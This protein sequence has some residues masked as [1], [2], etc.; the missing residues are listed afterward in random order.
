MVDKG[1]E[2]A[3][4]APENVPAFSTAQPAYAR[5]LQRLQGTWWKRIV[6]V[7]APYRRHIRRLRLGRLLDIGCGTGRNLVHVGGAGIGIDHNASLV[8]IARAGGLEAYTPDEFRLSAHAQPAE[9]DSLLYS[10]ILEHM[11]FGEAQQLL[12]D[13]LPFLRLG[14]RVVMITP[15]E[16]GY[17]SDPTHVEF[18]DFGKVVRLADGAGLRVVQTY[19]FPLPRWVGKVF[20]YNEFVVIAR[21]PG[22]GR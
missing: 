5:R 19:S 2:E 16:R 4:V 18:M 6:P 20:P 9:F 7:Q 11:S 3:G 8:E 13:Y 22:P 10:H 12:K 14:G 15:Q 21:L 1:R 17:A